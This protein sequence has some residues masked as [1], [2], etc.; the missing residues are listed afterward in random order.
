MK[1]CPE[2][3]DVLSAY[4]D[5][6]L[7]ESNNRQVEDHLAVCESCSA[8]LEMYRE[9]SVSVNESNAPVPDALRIGVMNRVL[10]E[11]TPRAAE[12]E[13]KRRWHHVFFT[14]Y[15]PVAACLAV[16]FLVWQ[17]WGSI[18]PW[19]TENGTFTR[20]SAPAPMAMP[21]A[22]GDMDAGTGNIE[23]E[24]SY[25]LNDDDVDMVT[26]DVAPAPMDAP[27]DALHPADRMLPGEQRSDRELESI[28]AYINGAYAEILIIGELP[29]MLSDYEPEPFGSWFNWEMV[30]EIPADGVPGLLSE[31]GDREEVTVTY[32]DSNST[33]AV[34]MYSR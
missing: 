10:H 20:D 13:A 9:I 2:L 31:L 24:D 19:N 3:E 22:G 4:A 15:A 7:D 11:D 29:A 18:R 16:A 6:E 5:S 23:A 33:Y 21:A 27:V 32:N 8:F 1:N 25:S 26:A 28:S 12:A 14:R 17:S 30:F 34:V